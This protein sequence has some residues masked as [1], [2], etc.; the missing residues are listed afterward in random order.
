MVVEWG[1]SFN[2]HK[3]LLRNRGNKLEYIWLRYLDPVNGFSN[4]VSR[5]MLLA[6]KEWML[7]PVAIWKVVKMLCLFIILPTES[8]ITALDSW[9]DRAGHPDISWPPLLVWRTSGSWWEMKNSS[10]YHC[11]TPVLIPVAPVVLHP[12]ASNVLGP[13][14]RWY[15]GHLVVS[16]DVPT[17]WC[18]STANR[19]FSPPELQLTGRHCTAGE[20]TEH[21]FCL[22]H[23]SFSDPP[24]HSQPVPPHLSLSRWTSPSFQ[25]HLE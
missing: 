7:I 5:H 8:Y 9:V 3:K 4:T 22:V 14:T 24:K 25:L 2:N 10:P 11:R 23:A 1:W 12:W 19:I 16:S 15:L 17:V 6:W 21:G 18:S 20:D 13:R